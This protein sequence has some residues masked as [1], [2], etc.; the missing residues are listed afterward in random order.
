M[1][2]LGILLMLNSLSACTLFH[3]ESQTGSIEAYHLRV[4]H[5]TLPKNIEDIQ[6]RRTLEDIDYNNRVI[7]R[8]STK[9][10]SP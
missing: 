10:P 2:L 7:E 4:V 6:P 3:P 5:L 1:R 9:T 8:E